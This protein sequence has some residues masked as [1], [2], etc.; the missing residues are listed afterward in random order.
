V[1]HYSSGAARMAEKPVASL[2][3]VTAGLHPELSD[4]DFFRFCELVHQHAGI[5]LTPQ[6]KE[7]VRARLVKILRQRGLQNFREYYEQVMRDT[8]GAELMCFLDALSTNQTAFWR[9]PQHFQYLDEEILPAW[10]PGRRQPF[11]GNLW[12]A[13][14]SSGEE[15]YTLAILLMNAFPGEDLSQVKIYASDLNTQV[16]AQAER[17][18]YPISRVDPLPIEWRQRFFQKGVRER[19]GFVRVKPEVRRLV[20][21]FRLNL[22]DP[23]PFR[24]NMDII[25]CHN[26]MIYFEKE[27]QLKL[28]DKFYQCLRPGGYLFIGHSESLCNHRHQFSYVKPTI[29][30]K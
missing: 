23:L 28:V 14:C 3:P 17:G 26:V 2:A 18:I 20:N 5:Y 6:K 29:Y 25:F 24:E 8:S 1:V 21:F 27:T 4:R 12:S 9:E 7:L 15:P 30:R 13:G 16:L 11:R 22:M 19:Q 10:P